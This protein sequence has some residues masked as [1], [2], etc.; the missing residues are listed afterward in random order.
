MQLAQSQISLGEQPV[1]L[2]TMVSRM[3]YKRTSPKYYTA[4]C[5]PK[6]ELTHEI[7]RWQSSSKHE[8][9]L[10]ANTS[11]MLFGSSAE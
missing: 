10:K 11:D 8:G 1:E 4:S 3:I 9:I 7:V 5:A 2:A 6:F